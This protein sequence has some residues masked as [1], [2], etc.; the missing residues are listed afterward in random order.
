MT[1]LQADIVVLGA[2]VVGVCCALELQKLGHKVTLIDRDGIGEGCSKGNA[3]H[4]ATE[5]ILPLASPGL[6]W[7]I[8]QMLLDPL[9][10]V[11]IRWSY[12]HKIAPWLIRFMLNTRSGPFCQGVEALNALNNEALP[13]WLTVLSRVGEKKKK[14]SDRKRL[15]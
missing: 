1:S 5:Q 8:P 10:P 11:S 14:K 9:G 3:G 13:G 7:K 15:W 4:F 6:M 12:L 2:G